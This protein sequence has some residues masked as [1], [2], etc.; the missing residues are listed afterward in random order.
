MTTVQ[1]PLRLRA[2]I[3]IRLSKATLRI[4]AHAGLAP[5]LIVAKDADGKLGGVKATI[6]K[7]EF[8]E[9]LNVFNLMM[10]FGGGV[11]VSF[12]AD[13]DISVGVDVQYDGALLKDFDPDDS[14]QSY[15]Y[16]TLRGGAYV[17]FGL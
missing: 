3:P 10:L 4:F 14:S 9:D 11:E 6:D 5:A 16:D 7:D 8:F 1:I 17:R 12:G 2:G 15:S 13:D